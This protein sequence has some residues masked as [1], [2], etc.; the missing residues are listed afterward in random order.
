MLQL[1]NTEFISF[2]ARGQCHHI[3]SCNT[4]FIL[5]RTQT[6][7]FIK[8]ITDRIITLGYTGKRFRFQ[9]PLQISRKN[10]RSILGTWTTRINMS[11]KWSLNYKAYL[12]WAIS[13][14]TNSTR[15]KKRS[16]IFISIFVTGTKNDFSGNFLQ[17]T[18]EKDLKF[19]IYM[20]TYN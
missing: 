9:S 10:I 7:L 8:I 6:K 3:T 20:Q 4:H 2:M 18:K 17:N 5:I 12:F 11:K 13:S 14:F 16:K 1:I 19:T 15:S